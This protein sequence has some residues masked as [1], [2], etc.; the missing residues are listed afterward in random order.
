MLHAHQKGVI[1]RDIKPSSV[2]VTEENGI[3]V[4][5]IIDFGIAKAT[6][7]QFSDDNLHTRVGTLIG[8]PGYMSPEQ[9]GVV[10]LDVDVRADVYSL[11]VLLYEL[12]V[13]FQPVETTIAAK[14][15]FEIQ[16]AIRDEEPLRPGRRLSQITEEAGQQVS[17][18]R[19]TRLSALRR[20]LESDIE[21][22]L[23]K[24]LDK[25]RE[26]RYQSATEFSADIARFVDGMPV[27]A[28]A[29]TR[30]Y[31]ASKFVRRHAVGVTM[32]AVFSA[33]VLAFAGTM[34]VQSVRLQQ[35]LEETTLERNHA[36]QVSDFMVEL[37]EAA[38]PEISGESNV[39]AREMLDR[40]T[41]RPQDEL[42]NQPELRARLLRTVGETYRVLGGLDNAETSIE[43][44]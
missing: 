10:S 36:E 16:K 38:N 31:R 18:N 13:G 7:Q 5:K 37:F 24:A 17:Q 1:H 22:I 20:R 44:F 14:G 42:T 3:P 12:L 9:A 39:T 6:E 11:G 27:L 4:P 26:R 32:A 21:W 25:N 41:Q 15:L 2:I 43:L 8:T 28:R 35:A 23:L 19:A 29:P 40:G 33:M 30:R 34:T